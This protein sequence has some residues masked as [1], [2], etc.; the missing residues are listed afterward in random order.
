MGLAQKYGSAHSWKICEIW[1]LSLKSTT[2]PR[3]EL[4][5]E[6]GEP[7]QPQMVLLE[8]PFFINQSLGMDYPNPV[9][10]KHAFLPY[11]NI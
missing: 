10:A 3:E 5:V 4:P 1:C 7:K 6:R 2:E 11:T 9:M 8:S